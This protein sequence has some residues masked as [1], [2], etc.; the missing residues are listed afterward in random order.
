MSFPS[1]DNKVIAIAAGSIGALALGGYL[2]FRTKKTADGLEE[3]STTSSAGGGTLAYETKKAVDEYLL[4]HFGRPE[5]IFPYA[6]GPKDALDFAARCAQL[7]EKHCKT[8][9]DISGEFGETA[10]L[11][12]GCAVGGSSFELARSFQHVLGV[13]YSQAFIDAAERMRDQGA[14]EYI[15]QVEGDITKKCMA[16]VPGD[17]QRSR[18]KFIKV[19]RSL[20]PHLL[21]VACQ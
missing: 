1:I 11:D 6:N 10:A 16:S 15:A 12:V 4:F 9:Q 3:R 17:I 21:P 18:A 13:D 14:S 7:C 5:D 8:L 20:C 19:R 2:L